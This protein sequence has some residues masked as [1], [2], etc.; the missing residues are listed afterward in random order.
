MCLRP[1]RLKPLP[2]QPAPAPSAPA[3]RQAGTSAAGQTVH[4]CQW[5]ERRNSACERFCKRRRNCSTTFHAIQLLRG[6]V[7]LDLSKPLSLDRAIRIGLLRQNSIA[8][9][10][11][12][13]DVARNRL[14]QARSSYFPQVTPSFQYQSTVT[15]GRRTI[16]G[17]STTTGTTSGITS[18]AGLSRQA[19]GGTSTGSDPGTGSQPARRYGYRQRNRYG[20]RHRYRVND[21]DRNRKHRNGNG[22]WYRNRYG[23]NGHYWFLCVRKPHGT[24]DSVTNHL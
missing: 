4:G 3:A 17:T 11:T 21:R 18:A 19:G 14:V 22:H 8:I 6:V 13:I 20:N 2:R 5:N 12:Q 15:P 23:A 10:Q 1:L 16:V 7:D 9:A 24:A